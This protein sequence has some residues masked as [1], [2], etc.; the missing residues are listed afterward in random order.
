MKLVIVESP[1]AG[2][3]EEHIQYAQD[4]LH[5]CLMRG[6]APFASHLLYTQPGVLRDDVPHERRQGI[7]AGHAWMRV[8]DYVVVYVNLGISP[9]M[10]KGIDAAQQ[11]GLTVHYRRLAHWQRPPQPPG[12]QTFAQSSDSASSMQEFPASS[13]PPPEATAARSRPPSDDPLA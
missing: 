3:V 9:G 6:E 1:Y 13:E 10:Q 4:A 7:D 12:R 5:D 11:R 2:A 8:A